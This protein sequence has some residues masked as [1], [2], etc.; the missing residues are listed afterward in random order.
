M[1]LGR[2]SGA[3]HTSVKVGAPTSGGEQC[4]GGSLG[5]GVR[6]AG[7]AGARRRLDVAEV[8]TGARATGLVYTS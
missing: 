6:V 8:G 2:S 5:G 7:Q 3:A 4:R 1:K